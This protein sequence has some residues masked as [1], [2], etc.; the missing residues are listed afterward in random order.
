VEHAIRVSGGGTAV[1][2]AY[3]LADAEH[4]VEKELR[5]AWPAA[6]VQV[7]DVS[8]PA[9]P[10]RIVE[11]FSVAY[12]IR[13]TIIV[14]AESPENAAREAFR[15]LRALFSGTRYTDLR[16]DPLASQSPESSKASP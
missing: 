6:Q 15:R 4:Q 9:G 1:V 12:R 14:E 3:G 10:P 8:R 11:D 13:G 5:E 16:W 2:P 7:M